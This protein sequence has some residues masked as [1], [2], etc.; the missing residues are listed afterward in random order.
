MYEVLE[1]FPGQLAG[2]PCA[3]PWIAPGC[4]GNPI[5][6]ALD[7]RLD[8]TNIVDVEST[9]FYS[10]VT[11]ALTDKLNITAGLRNTDEEKTV[12]G[13]SYKIAS[14]SYTLNN[15]T[16]VASWKETTSMLSID[17]HVSDDLMTY[18]SLSEGF[19]SGGFN[20]RPAVQT[21][22]AGFARH[23]ACANHHVRVRGIGAGRDRGCRWRKA[24]YNDG[25]RS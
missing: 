24:D 20:P 15:V 25:R 11:Y 17:Y 21:Q 19:K 8:V 10:Q 5:N 18:I 23:K 13:N 4:K 16:N 12:F 9:A 7:I 14:K 6:I 1:T 22:R 3:P 2:T